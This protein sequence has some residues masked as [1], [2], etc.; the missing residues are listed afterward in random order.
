MVDFGLWKVVPE[1]GRYTAGLGRT[2]D[3]TVEDLRQA[4]E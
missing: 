2:Y 1:V 3:V 4:S